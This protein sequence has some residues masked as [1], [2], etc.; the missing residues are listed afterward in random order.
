MVESLRLDVGG[1][2]TL[3]AK[4]FPPEGAGPH[5]CVV[6]SHG[7]G[8]VMDMGLQPYAEAFAAAG[9]ACLVYD[10]RNFGDSDG[11]VR[12]EVDPWQQIRD[13][14][15]VIGQARNRADVDGSRIG[16]W[17]TSYSGGHVLVIGAVDRRVK[18]VVSQVPVTSGSGAIEAMVPADQ[19]AGWREGVYADY[20]ARAAGEAP[21]RLAVYQPGGET[22]VWAETLGPGTSYLNEVGIYN[23]KRP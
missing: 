11:E 3:A 14:R 4:F 15:E 16:L 12:Q 6:M 9:L 20:D 18:C 8:A 10:H 17:G 23:G 1:G 21:A 2:V 19:M 13:M 7:F 5:P 22:A